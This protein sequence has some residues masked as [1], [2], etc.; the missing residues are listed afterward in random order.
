MNLQKEGEK[1]RFVAFF[2]PDVKFGLWQ[3]PRGNT[4]ALGWSCALVTELL[5][6]PTTIQDGPLSSP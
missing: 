4:A 1:K 2:P 6:V 3:W 5:G